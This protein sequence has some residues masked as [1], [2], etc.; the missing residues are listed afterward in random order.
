ME[1][2]GDWPESEIKALG[3]LPDIRGFQCGKAGRKT[4]SI[5]T[6]LHADSV[7]KTR[8]QFAP[9][10]R[11]GSRNIPD[12]DIMRCNRME[13]ASGS[14]ICE[15]NNRTY[16]PAILYFEAAIMAEH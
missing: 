16:R 10:Q 8:S 3:F 11:H 15:R 14:S 5:S 9:C 7:S 4:D 1:K 12:N 13:A 2:G 6:P